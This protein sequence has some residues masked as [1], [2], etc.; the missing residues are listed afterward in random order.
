MKQISRTFLTAC[1]LPLTLPLHAQNQQPEPYSF[2]RLPLQKEVYAQLPLGSIKAK[3]WLLKQLE[4]QKDGF[5][6]HAEELYPDRNDL[7]PAADWLGG[8]GNS[9]EKAPYYLKGLVALAYTLD[10]PGLKQKAQKWIEYTLDHQQES[11]LFGPAKMKDWWPRMPFMY[12]LQSYYEATGDKRV[13]PFLSR[14]LKYQLANLDGDPLKEWGKSRAGD[15]IEI[16]IWVYN[17]TGDKFL[18]ELAH[19]LKE[20][21]YPWAEIFNENQFDYF[22]ND[23]QPKHMVNVAQALKFPA[24][25]AQVDS[26]MQYT[27]AMQNGIKHLLQDHGQ[28]TGIAAGTERISGKSSVQGVETC[29]VVEWMQSLETA[30]RI[31]HDAEIGDQLEKIAFNALPAQFSKDLKSHTYYTLPNQV[32]SLPGPHGFNQDYHNGIIPGPYSGFPCCRYNMHMGWPYFVKNSWSATPEGGLAVIAYGPMEVSTVVGDNKKIKIDEDTGYPFE[33]QIR[34]TVFV[35]SPTSFPLTLRIPSW[36]IN[37]QV[38]INNKL[39]TG[40]SAGKLLTLNRK[41]SN[42]DKVVLDFPMHLS[43]E[44]Q[45]NN[46]VS[47]QRGPLVYALKIDQ[48]EKRVKEFPVKGFFETEISAASAW[49]YGLLLDGTPLD[50]QISVIKRPMPVNPFVQQLTPVE[51]KVKAKKISTWGLDYNNT[52]AFDVPFS[53][54][55]SDQPAEE[56]TLVPYGSESL[57]LSILPV[58]GNPKFIDKNYQETFGANNA[59]GLVIYGGGWFYRNGAVHSSSNEDGRSGEGTKIIA[60][61]TKFADLMFSADIAVN[62]PGNGGLLFRIKDPAIGANAYKGYYLGLNP[63]TE[64]IEFGKAN[65]KVWTVIAAARYPLE[66]KKNYK[67]EIKAVGN[68]FEVLID[69]NKEPVLIAQDGDYSEGSIGLRA[70]NA[71]MTVD[72]IKVTGL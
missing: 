22:G 24:I 52:A 4:L 20:Q 55:F 57:R 34:L 45:V 65:G 58:I 59:K 60:T 5:T 33:E 42:G 10:D 39:I 63:S 68:T 46:A 3:G 21:S 1:L 29:T 31:I 54:A 62:T 53:P 35:D 23:Y 30:S 48:S 50:K 66:L 71:L 41:W 70:Y 32:Q 37:P 12:A 9:W 47:I 13:I 19:K 67:L 40:V 26:S 14:Y 44:K 72:N 15:N 2:N 69:G 38:R 36:C 8:T 16:A 7:G 51:L 27:R 61:G 56:V 49:N 18:L 17:K 64:T 25:Y 43:T 6:G 28:P 11:G